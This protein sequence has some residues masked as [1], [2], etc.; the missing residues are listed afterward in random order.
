MNI[1]PLICSLLIAVVHVHCGIVDNRIEKFKDFDGN[2]NVPDG[3]RAEIRSYQA[4]VD[5]I[6][7]AVLNGQF[8]GKTW[9]R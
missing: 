5:R 7:E 6:V 4:T 9:Q 2:C 3:L 1:I 8:K